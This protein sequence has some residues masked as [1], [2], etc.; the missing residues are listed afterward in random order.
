MSW[1]QALEVSGS[2]VRAASVRMSVIAEN[3]ANADATRTP[4]GGPYRRRVV[5]LGSAPSGPSGWPGRG[6]DV[7]GAR[8]GVQVLGIIA[9]QEPLRRVYQPGHPDADA[10]GYVAVPNVE[11]PLE[12]ADLAVANRVYQANTVALQ[13]LRRSLNDTISLL[14]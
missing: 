9:T 12:M 7:G 1:W 8:L 3:V 10:Q 5:L 6:A 11:V 14:G 13:T 2:G 4:E